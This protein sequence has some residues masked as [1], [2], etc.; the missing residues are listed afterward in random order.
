MTAELAQRCQSAKEIAVAAGAIAQQR[1]DQGLEIADKGIQDFV[2]QADTEVERFIS[3]ALLESFPGEGIFGEEHPPQPSA[4][5]TWV[6]DP[7]DGTTNFLKGMDYWC[8]SIAFVRDDQI[9]LGCIYA[10]D[11]DELY[12]AYV[13]GGSELNGEPLPAL[14][15][16][17]PTRAIL[18]LGRSNRASFSAYLNDLETLQQLDMDYRRLGS[19][20]LSLAHIAR[21][22]VDGYYEAHL[23]SWDACAGLI[24]AAEAG[25]E[26]CHFLT[27]D[28]L[29]QGNRTLAANPGVFELL[30][31][32]LS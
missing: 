29:A 28:A 7:I 1:R 20:A 10:P 24:I 11:R 27:A 18:A 9:L 6:I 8:I 19:A 32:R 17:E 2:T 25:A 3:E 31:A 12:S 16:V 5:G 26:C 30:D 14:S 21:G 13:G 23:N 15:K 22:E 4:Q